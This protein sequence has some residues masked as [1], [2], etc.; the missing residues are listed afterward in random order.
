MAL[1]AVAPRS[2]S[3][4]CLALA[5]NCALRIRQISTQIPPRGRYRDADG[6]ATEESE[7]QAEKTNVFTLGVLAFVPVVGLA[8][9]IYDA[10]QGFSAGE[11]GRF[12][13]WTVPIL[14]V[15]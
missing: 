14:W 2:M 1:D 6:E 11:G 9:S 13:D 4:V 15:C 10:V 8:L 5:A 3:V 7:R 12:L